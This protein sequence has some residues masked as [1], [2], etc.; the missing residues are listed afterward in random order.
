MFA[1]LAIS[2]KASDGKGICRA[3]C[4]VETFNPATEEQSR[5]EMGGIRNAL[6]IKAALQ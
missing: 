1:T 5:Y 4:W 2:E 3:A 6:Q